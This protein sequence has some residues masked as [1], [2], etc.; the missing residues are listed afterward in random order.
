MENDLYAEKLKDL[1]NQG[2]N[3]KNQQVEGAAT[4]LQAVVRGLTKAPGLLEE[5]ARCARR[6]E[7]LYPPPPKIKDKQN[8]PQ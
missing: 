7:A 3:S 6:A 2:K 5:L 8:E 4:V 1:V